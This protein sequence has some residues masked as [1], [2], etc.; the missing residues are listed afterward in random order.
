M[1]CPNCGYE[2][3]E[4]RRYCEGCGD[5]LSGVEARRARARSKTQREAAR[6]RREVEKGDLPPEVAERRI[7]RQRRVTKPW[8]GLVVLALVAAALILL[9]VWLWPSGKSGPEK[10]VTAF[11]EAIRDKDVK[12]YYKYTEYG[13]YKMA[14]EG[15]VELDPYAAGLED[16]DS[17]RLE[18]LETRLVKEEGD[19]AEVEVTGGFFQGYNESGSESVGVDFSSDPRMI[20]LVKVEG[21]WQIQDYNIVRQPYPSVEIYTE[22]PEFPEVEEGAQEP[23]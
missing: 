9:L 22:E 19:Y 14:E 5:K 16:W 4:G 13:L 6:M 18:N 10:A 21:V 3:P 2:N 15:E 1:Q 12:Q 23:G 17:Y 7:R 8:M 20:N 11:F